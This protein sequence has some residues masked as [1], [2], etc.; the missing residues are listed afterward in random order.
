MY[1][2]IQVVT[3]YEEGAIPDFSLIK[4]NVADQYV[5]SKRAEQYD[6]LLQSLYSKYDVIINR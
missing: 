2:V 1:N 3:K 5:S 4:N 6:D